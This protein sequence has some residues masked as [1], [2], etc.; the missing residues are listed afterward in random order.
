MHIILT[1]AAGI[2]GSHTLKYLL[3][4]GHSVDAIDI[5]PIAP[6]VLDA[7]PKEASER[8]RTHVA[9]LVDLSKFEAIVKAAGHVDGVIHNGGIPN[10]LNN[11]PR[12][13]YNTNVTSNYNVLQTCAKYGIFRIAQASSVNAYGMSFTPEGHKFWDELPMNEQSPAR[14]E[15]PYA[16]SKM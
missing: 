4:R 13:V 11:D 2:V 1:G 10:P 14:P 5:V 3:A 6:T 9:D 7:I 16:T 12:V 15:D 8:L